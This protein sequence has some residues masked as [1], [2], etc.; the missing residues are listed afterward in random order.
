[1][2]M[3]SDYELFKQL[4]HKRKITIPPD[5]LEAMESASFTGILRLPCQ[6]IVLP[7]CEILGRVLSSSSTIRSVDLS[8][9]MLISKGLSRIFEALTE[10][11]ALTALN[12]KGNNI[13]GAVVSQLGE[14]FH[15]NHTLRILNLEWNSLGTDTEC[16]SKFCEGLS[17]NNSLEEL[18][19]RYNQISPLCT[20]ALT[21]VLT[22]NKSLK[23]LNLG[24]NNLGA[25]GGQAILSS[26][27]EN[28]TI[29]KL[30]LRGNCIPEEILTIIEDLTLKNQSREIQSLTNISRAQGH[31]LVVLHEN[32]QIPSSTN[33]ES[34]EEDIILKKKKVKQK[35]NRIPG[36]KGESTPF[37]K[38]HDDPKILEDESESI[39]S[40]NIVGEQSRPSESGNYPLEVPVKK[41]DTEMFSKITELNRMLQER[42]AVINTLMKE[43]STKDEEIRT[44]KVLMKQL[45]DEMAELKMKNEGVNE[46]K[47]K[48]IE[49]MRESQR[50]SEDTLRKLQRQLEDKQREL[51]EKSKEW[52]GQA[53]RYD[54]DVQRNSAALFGLREKFVNKS[55]QYEEVISNYKTEIHRIKGELKERVNRHKIEINV[56]KRTLKETTEALEECQVQL[57]KSRV[58]LREVQDNLSVVKLRISEMEG[59]SGKCVRLEETFQKLKEEKIVVEEKFVEAQRTVASL[60]RQVG[61]LETELVEP[62][63]RYNLLKEELENEREKTA[64]M[65][66]E[67]S[68]E[69][70]RLRDQDCQLQKM[71]Q[72]ITALNEQ[73]SEI[74]R[75]HAEEIKERERERKMLK[76]V[77]ANKDRDLREVRAEEAQRAGLLYAA[78][79]K[80]LGSIGSNNPL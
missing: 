71:S 63:R 2:K 21:K 39:L 33:E 64:R 61:S 23:I 13:A 3:L 47:V 19:L 65:K 35:K 70:A 75:G 24:R 29:I 14:I 9:C 67:L 8:D 25:Q 48:E 20:E 17:C 11:S 28:S 58:E 16:F 74:Q 56:L 22:R 43:I 31:K 4:C 10:G 77:I 18:D 44:M 38:P 78:F 52:E 7:V 26:M 34:V 40:L 76:E 72:Q 73:M 51:E 55:Q 59:I 6:S 66:E 30:N 45:Q 37:K 60:K 27:K 79:T 80:Y 53:R 36:W 49:G 1:M 32:H 12:L 62:Q 5:I 69:R 46:E 41:N 57:Q 42:S 50:V 68:G 54:G 15:R